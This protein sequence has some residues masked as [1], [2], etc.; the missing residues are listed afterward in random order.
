MEVMCLKVPSTAQCG[1][2]GSPGA[3]VWGCRVAFVCRGP[4]KAVQ[5]GLPHAQALRARMRPSKSCMGRLLRAGM[6]A[7]R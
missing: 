4:S 5:S 2:S 3:F 7:P 6:I 1:A